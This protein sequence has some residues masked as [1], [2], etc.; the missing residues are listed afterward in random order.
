[1]KLKKVNIPQTGRTS[2]RPILTVSKTGR[3]SLSPMMREK[4]GYETGDRLNFHQDEESPKDW[5]I[6][7]DREEGAALQEKT[8]DKY[9]AVFFQNSALAAEIRQVFKTEGGMTFSIGAA[10]EQGGVNYWPL[11]FN[12]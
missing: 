4:T 11:L 10:T 12:K 5:Y 6:T 7:Y 9:T 8:A 1:M 2:S 3:F